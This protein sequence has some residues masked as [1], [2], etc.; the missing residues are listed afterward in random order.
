VR[1]KRS[2]ELYI[3]CGEATEE[4]YRK[5]SPHSR[6]DLPYHIT[7]D[8]KIEDFLLWSNRER[9]FIFIAKSIAHL[10]IEPAELDKD[11]MSVTEKD[12]DAQN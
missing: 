4:D 9:G 7:E 11:T 12:S 3:F 2:G 8:G 1:D 5:Y 6:T 10:Y